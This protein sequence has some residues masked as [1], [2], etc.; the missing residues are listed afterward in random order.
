MGKESVKF[1]KDKFTKEGYEEPFIVMVAHN[2]SHFDVPFLVDSL[3][4][5]KVSSR[6][7]NMMHQID[8]LLLDKHA[9]ITGNL[10]S[11]DNYQLGTLY[12]YFTGKD[13]GDYSHRA[14]TDS[15]EA[16]EILTLISFWGKEI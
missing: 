9:V 3:S 7:L 12:K 15:Q 11:T 10:T 16:V 1:I 2:G 14:S 13:I 6:G 8:T 4:F 5:Y